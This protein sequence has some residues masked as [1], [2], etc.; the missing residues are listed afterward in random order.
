RAY[1]MKTLPLLAMLPSSAAGTRTQGIRRTRDG[2]G[3]GPYA[4]SMSGR[5]R[6]KRDRNDLAGLPLVDE[7]WEA[8][9]APMRT[10]LEPSED[11]PM[12]AGLIV[13]VDT[14][15]VVGV[16]VDGEE[17]PAAVVAAVTATMRTPLNGTPRRPSVVRVRDTAAGR[18]LEKVLP[19]GTEVEYADRLPFVEDVAA[20]LASA[21]DAGGEEEPDLED[22]AAWLTEEFFDAAATWYEAEPWSVL[23]PL[24]MLQLRVGDGEPF[25]ASVL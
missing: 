10:E 25:V 12:A 2:S 9:S 14:V 19:P 24:T 6:P 16:S 21:T 18:R 17:G 1:E 8:G 13:D 23:D 4:W 5:Q 22:A 20:G 3:A 7:V 11:M 15:S